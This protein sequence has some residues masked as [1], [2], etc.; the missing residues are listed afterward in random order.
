MTSAHGGAPTP[1]SSGG[2]QAAGATPAHDELPVE[3]SLDEMSL[4][5]AIHEVELE[6][7]EGRPP[8]AGRT[9]YLVTA[10]VV[11]AL[12]VAGLFG[13]AA[14]GLGSAASPGAGTWSM[15]VS[16]ATVVLGLGLVATVRSSN[17]AEQFTGSSLLV[18]AGLGSMVL[19]VV[20]LPVIGFEIPAALLCLVWLR[21]LGRESWRLSLGLSLVLVAAFYVL[22]VGALSVPIP[23]LL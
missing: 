12:G 9:S 22:F 11:I 21:F 18:L 17:D 14:L 16:L 1:D 15:L 5:E 19:F 20:L 3:P 8:V 7:H 23:H 4:T 13:S 6:E 2:R 10:V